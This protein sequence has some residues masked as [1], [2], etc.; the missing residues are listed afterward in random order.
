MFMMCHCVVEGNL[1]S[2]AALPRTAQTLHVLLWPQWTRWTRTYLSVCVAT[3]WSGTVATVKMPVVPTTRQRRSLI[4][5]LPT[6]WQFA[7]RSCTQAWVGRLVVFTRDSGAGAGAGRPSSQAL[8]STL[9]IFLSS[10]VPPVPCPRGC[11][12]WRVPSLDWPSS[13]GA[14][15]PLCCCGHGSL[16]CCV[17]GG[18][19]S[20][21]ACASSRVNVF[22]NQCSASFLVAR[23]GGRGQ[24]LT[25]PSHRYDEGMSWSVSK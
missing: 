14:V 21:R 22:A 19:V 25:L 11:A 13:W 15:H 23:K 8:I 17:S 24:A 6:C 12:V 4:K 1:S 2:T 18:D 5:R 7:H 9:P 20:W 10:S 16:F 3:P